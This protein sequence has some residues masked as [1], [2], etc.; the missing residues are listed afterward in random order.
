MPRFMPQKE[1]VS[2]REQEWLT[3][4]DVTWRHCSPR[5]PSPGNSETTGITVETSLMERAKS[6]QE[7]NTEQVPECCWIQ[8]N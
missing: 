6:V 4:G 1:H 7:N 8:Y 3:Q 5:E 2:R